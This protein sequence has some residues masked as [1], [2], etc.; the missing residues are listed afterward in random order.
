MKEHEFIE[1]DFILGLLR[2]NAKKI[3]DEI[4]LAK[5]IKCGQRL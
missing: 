4:V 3:F 1:I 2:P 5:K